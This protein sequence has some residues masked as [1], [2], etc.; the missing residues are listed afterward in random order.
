[1][2]RYS[3]TVDKDGSFTI[4]DM[5]AGDYRLSVRF[6]EKPG[7]QL[8]NY[9]FSVSETAAKDRAMLDLGDLQLAN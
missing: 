5:S 6:W 2:P 9:E 1:L 3:A 7:G 8:R 4:Y